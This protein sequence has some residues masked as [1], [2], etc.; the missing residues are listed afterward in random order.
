MLEK[1][2]VLLDSKDHLLSLVGV[3]QDITERKIFENE[4]IR[5]QH[6][7]QQAQKMES[8]GQLTGG[9][10]HDFNNLLGIINGYTGLLEN[11]LPNHKDNKLV[12]YVHNIS[13][14][15]DRAATLIAQM[16]SFSRGDNSEVLAI[17]LPEILKGEIKML[18]STLPSTIEIKDFIDLNL[19]N[20][21][22]NPAQFHQIVMNLSINARDAMDGMGMLTIRLEWARDL[23]TQST[24]SHKP[25]KG[26]WIE[27]SVTDNGSGIDDKTRDNLF[28]P[29]FTTKEV[30]KGTGMG[31]SVIYRIM[32]QHNGHIILE[33]EPGSGSTFR[34]LFPPIH[35]SGA[36]QLESNQK[37][38]EIPMGDGSEILVVD[39][40]IM[41]STQISEV[42]N[43]NGYK[44][45]AI[46][47]SL[48]ALEL[49]KK[50]PDRFSL[51]ITDQTMP[52]MTGVDLIKKIRE[53]RPEL[54]VIMCSG[55]SD[56][57]NANEA[58]VLDISY[59]DKPA[60]IDKLLLKIAELLGID[61]KT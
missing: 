20:V 3:I 48:G 46:D 60:N 47:D 33:S 11:K 27:L 45:T 55:Y 21:L 25:I 16:L 59:F 50:D 29:F 19:P 35:D 31:L 1:G 4:N 17:K 5:M 54:P 32:E 22:M 42:V 51:L 40:E 28:N 13:E 7:L 43:L 37:S 2:D 36:D 30:G 41:L 15:G 38:V 23:D 10:A 49:F 39:D 52:K 58:G 18:R 8:L 26:D 9:I 34:M 57:I 24:V 14:A 6:E 53:I 44:S 56:K 12:D 61:L